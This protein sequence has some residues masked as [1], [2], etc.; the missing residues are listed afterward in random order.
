MCLSKV[1]RQTR[2]SDEKCAYDSLGNI[3]AMTGSVMNSFCFTGREWDT[4][5]RLY[6]YR[7]RYFDPTTGRFFGEDPQGFAA[8]VN[9][10]AYSLKN[11]TTYTDPFGL[12]VIVC[13]FPVPAGSL[14]DTGYGKLFRAAS[15]K[16]AS[17]TRG[18]VEGPLRSHFR[19][20]RLRDRTLGALDRATLLFP[21]ALSTAG[22]HSVDGHAA[23][24][25]SSK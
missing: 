10:Y 21:R 14:G 12:G 6:Y 7:A 5:T 8:G 16:S 1:C 25:K 17:R 2:Y 15:F 19:E 23:S 9:F 13:Y 22:T 3:T 11:P 4:E 20:C 24:G 18:F